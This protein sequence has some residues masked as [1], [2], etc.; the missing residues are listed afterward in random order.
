[1]SRG[2]GLIFRFGLNK[3]D[4]LGVFAEK[5]YGDVLRDNQARIN[6]ITGLNAEIPLSL[7]NHKSEVARIFGEIQGKA[8]SRNFQ[9]AADQFNG[10]LLP[11]LDTAEPEADEHIRKRNE[12]DTKRPPVATALDDLKKH[13]QKA[14][15]N[16]KITAAQTFLDDAADDARL[17]DL[18]SALDGVKNAKTECT[19]GKKFA[20]E[21]AK[22]VPKRAK[23]GVIVAAMKG[24]FSDENYWKAHSDH[25]V[26]ADAKA[27]PG[28]RKYVDACKMVDDV[29]VSLKG[30]LKTWYIDDTR[31]KIQALK[32]K[33]S[34]KAK[35]AELI[36]TEIKEIDKLQAEVESNLAADKWNR[37]IMA[38]RGQISSLLTLGGK[39]A[40]RRIAFDAERA[41]AVSAIDSLKSHKTLLGQMFSMNKLV[42]KA[43]GLATR[44]A[45]RFEDG[46]AELKKIAANCQ[47]LLKVAADA[48]AYN[49]ARV[50]A[51]QKLEALKKLPAAGNLASQIA[52]IEQQLKQAD[53]LTGDVET[54]GGHKIVSDHD[55]GSQDWKA[56]SGV[57]KQAVSDLT[58][59]E[60]LAAE[61][62]DA[63][64]AQTAAASAGNADEITKVIED[65]RKQAA[66]AAK[67]PHADLADHEFS[68][69]TSSLDEAADQAAGGQLEI[70]KIP[71]QGAAELLLTAQT[72]QREH[73]R[74]LEQHKLIDDRV[75][76]LNAL[77]DP[78]PDK[79]QAKINAIT[80]ALAEAT[81]QDKDRAWSKSAAAL[82]QAENA[83]TEAELVAQLRK[84][85][86][87]RAKVAETARN[88]L[89]DNPLKAKV[90]ETIT[91][92]TEQAT[93]FRFD[94]ADKGLGTAEAQIASA[95]AAILART[96]AAS[97]EF[98][99][100][101]KD[102]LKAEGGDKLIDD[103][104]KSLP[105]TD[106]AMKAMVVLAKERFGIELASDAGFKPQ[107]AKKMLE[108]MA[109]VPQ[110][111][112]G[113]PSLKKVERR[114]PGKNGGFYQSDDNL[115]VMNGRPGQVNQTF[116][117][118]LLNAAGQ[119]QLPDDVPDAYKPTSDA[120]L[121]YFDFATL[122]EVGHAVDDRMRFM[123][124]REEKAEFGGW[125]TYGANV[126]PIAKAVAKAK[127]YD[128]TPEQ[129]EYVTELI[130]GNSPEPPTPPSGQEAAWA[131]GLQKV[132]DWYAIA[133]NEKV[134]WS[135]SDSTAITIG[136][137]IYHEA[138]KKTWVSYLASERKK[139]M[140]GYQFRAPGEWFAELYACFHSGKLKNGH[141]AMK[142]IKSL[143]L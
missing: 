98:L 125:K 59:A 65:L 26:T 127:S 32:N 17:G 52:A 140:T 108:M 19:D 83:A 129:I 91:K 103:L 75:K 115:V 142:W 47:D 9:D 123:A 18:D 6:K 78:T 30:S 109:K 64:K 54:V 4:K 48:K 105:D 31:P 106:E 8:G 131:D 39:L 14:H 112:K 28:E 50:L 102:M 3:I 143:S 62:A 33:V 35:A 27:A 107:A 68:H 137:T 119:K 72:V 89:T 40:D 46:I 113:N 77:T 61:L 96:N 82:H 29:V 70:A 69:I 101:A 66:A 97:P 90:L 141:P 124:S 41:T 104:I 49:E 7:S 76:A 15:V 122:H 51:D 117:A 21:F 56:A 111:A 114:E 136:D 118:N 44:T 92:A 110:Q 11:L 138:Y 25:L 116:G 23:S 132:K 88:T 57:V 2:I 60:A 43:D 79:I 73:T 99:A 22:Y 71:L 55:A 120:A 86:D 1:M 100:K 58:A 130:L 10:E 135:Q 126:D 95:R 38:A 139:G 42:E 45:M 12:Y 37:A 85:F 13:A 67:K 24:L 5:L 63:T 81:K 133:T 36:D 128:S 93:A 20:D 121:D 74:F 94:V 87:A 34:G 53:K 134:W 80:T 84:Q 16:D